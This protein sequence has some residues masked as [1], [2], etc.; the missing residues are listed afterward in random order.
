[1]DWLLVEPP[2]QSAI[3][4][5]I[6]AAGIPSSAYL[7]PML[8]KEGEKVQ[9]EDAPTLNHNLDDI[10]KKIKGFHPNYVG[11]TAMTA[12]VPSAYDVARTV[13]ELDSDIKVV[14]GGPHPTFLPERT[15]EE[16]SAVDIVVRGEGEKTIQE[17]AGGQD[18]SDIKGIT[19]REKDEI[20]ENKERS[21]IEDLDDLPFPAYDLVPMDR[22]KVDG[23]RYSTIMTSRGCPFNC[24]FC[25]SSRVFGK[26]WRA[27]SPERVLEHLKLLVHDFDVHEV[28]FLDDTFTLNKSRAEKICDLITEKG[29]NISW[30][31]S[32][33]VDT[34]YE[35]LAE[36]LKEAGCHTVYIGIESGVQK[37]LD[38]LKKG[39]NIEQVKNAVKTVKDAGLN[40]VGSFILGA[41]GETRK[42]ME[43]T[44]EFAKDLGLS[45]AQ[46]TVFTPYP[47][48]KAWDMAKEK[49]LLLTEDWS[50][51]SVL[52][53][54][55][56]HSEMDV[57]ELKNFMRKAY[58]SFYLRPSSFWRAIKN[59][60]FWPLLKKGMKNLIRF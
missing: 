43:K 57:E 21:L 55:M 33:R 48:T 47:G 23:V 39:I 36:K 44:V 19:Y 6:G 12:T 1:M 40:T 37:I 11:I 2:A 4:D 14:M 34:I 41:P 29:L 25:S 17:L 56:K 26:K 38:T 27:K 58:L 49:G 10:K 20:V 53:P 50:K 31:C 54:V 15:L 5:S 32:S 9:I 8:R 16:C 3:Q 7:A 13:K 46:F 24:I 52:D 18:W 35:T 60:Y 59:G 45:L 30:S 22:Y 51:Y 28:E 42:Q